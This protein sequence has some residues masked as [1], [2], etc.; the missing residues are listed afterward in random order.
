MDIP[1]RMSPRRR[2]S[3]VQA[4]DRLG[5]DSVRTYSKVGSRGD[6]FPISLGRLLRFRVREDRPPS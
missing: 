3:P 2:L 6:Y 5:G 4:R 1:V